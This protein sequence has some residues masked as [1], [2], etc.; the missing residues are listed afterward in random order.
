MYWRTEPKQLSLERPKRICLVCRTIDPPTEPAYGCPECGDG[1]TVS[2]YGGVIPEVC[3]SC[4]DGEL[5]LVTENA[6]AECGQ[7]EV[8]ER[9][10]YPCP[11]C[12]EIRLSKYAYHAFISEEEFLSQNTKVKR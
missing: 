1:G 8:E 10:I 12:G 11:H 7:G 6:C 4:G 2:W 3:P 9:E 5:E